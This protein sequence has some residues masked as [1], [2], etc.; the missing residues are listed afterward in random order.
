MSSSCVP[1]SLRSPWTMTTI[2]SESWM[3]LSRCA[4]VNVVRPCRAAS[5]AFCTSF[6]ETESSAD[7]ASSSN[8]TE[9]SRMMALAMAQRCFWPPLSLPPRRPTGSSHRALPLRT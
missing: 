3:V 7:V 1:C 2:L 4:M 6:S 9:G 8:S 5:S